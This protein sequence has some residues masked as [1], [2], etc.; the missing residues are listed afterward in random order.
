VGSLDHVVDLLLE[1][2]ERYGISYI[3]RWETVET[4]APIIA[5]LAGR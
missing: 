2:R 4:I 1:R 5:R 3:S